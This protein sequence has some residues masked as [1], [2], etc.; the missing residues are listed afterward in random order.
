M[1]I[2]GRPRTV[3]AALA[4][5][6]LLA[7]CGTGPNQVGAAVLLD[8]HEIS[9]DQVQSLIDKAVQD[10]PAARQLSQQHKLDQVGREIVT[11]LIEHDLV[12]RA[13][14][15][16]GLV[17]DEAAVSSTLAQ[18][19]LATPVSATN[20]DPSQLARQ[21]VY[22]ARDHREVITDNVL[23]QQLAQRYFANM[24]VTF[25]YTSVT[26]DDGGT[27]PKSMRDKAFE[28]AEQMA[29]DPVAAARVI[30]TDAATNV[31]TGVGEKVPAVQAPDLAATVVFGVRPGTVIAFQPSQEQAAWIV[32]V[33]RQRDL[34]TPQ[35]VDQA[36]EP[37][38]SQLVAIGQRL[39]QPYADGIG[40]KVNPR[41]G[42]WD[43]V[44]MDVAP[45]AASTAGLV[46]PVKGST[47]P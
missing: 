46:V 3:L 2:I 20:V 15:R 31:E 42:V 29:A 21:L 26:S 27:E 33:V 17:A 41:Y 24:A 6:L 47:Q 4:G 19:P 12:Q 9:Q 40:L 11:Q 43:P 16:E 38:A 37:S 30:R 14:Q 22:R 32:A 36:A 5:A 28:K 39:L 18:D 13:A 10:Q 45:N 34:T 7:G 44:G 8:G 25:D 35:S 1:R 23:M